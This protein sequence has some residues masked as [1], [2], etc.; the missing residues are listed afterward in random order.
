M[1]SQQSVVNQLEAIER[2]AQKHLTSLQSLIAKSMGDRNE[3]HDHAYRDVC[4]LASPIF[5]W[6]GKTKREYP[7][8][9]Q[10]RIF[11]MAETELFAKIKSLSNVE[12]GIRAEAGLLEDTLGFGS[13]GTV[14]KVETE[15]GVKARRFI[16]EPTFSERGK[17]KPLSAW[18]QRYAAT[19]APDDRQ[20]ALHV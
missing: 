18:L 9:A 14:W 8:L 3:W 5:E 15:H 19:G 10:S 7:A 16:M 1:T 13:F 2:S 17:S 4:K 11:K 20:S 12:P 6:F